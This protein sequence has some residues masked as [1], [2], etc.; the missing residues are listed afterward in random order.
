M[1]SLAYYPGCSQT[2]TAKEYEMSVRA[3]MK[4]LGVELAELEDWSCCGST[5]AHT[6]DHTL[7][8]ALAARNLRIA[9]DMN[10]SR[11]ATPCP[12]CLS[13]LRNAEVRMEDEGFR[14]QVN[15]LLDVPFEGGVHAT[16]I[17][18]V[19]FEEIGPKNIAA[20]AV[21]SMQGM[22]AAPY[23]GCIM[24]RPPD[25]MKF[26]D[27][28]NPIAMDEILKALGAEV[29]DF[30]V[31]LEC[32][33]ASYS[34]PRKDIV[35]NLTGRVLGV[36]DRLGC[37]A[38]VVACPLCQQNLDLRQGQVNSTN[39]TSYNIPVLYITQVIGLA[40]GIAPEELGLSKLVVS[41]SALIG[42][43]GAKGDNA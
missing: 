6:V 16:S 27:P 25:V 21:K 41:P 8:A 39:G 23:Y 1:T 12:S 4:A 36:A 22:I 7:A 2:G 31:K 28:E 19:L 15:E 5:P 14:K 30:P 17:L 20:K 13:N 9:K 42:K 24:N 38:V 26:D 40:L 32:C 33:G 34:V 29:P 37:N 43:L 3:C 35:M 11:V 18:Q 10:Y